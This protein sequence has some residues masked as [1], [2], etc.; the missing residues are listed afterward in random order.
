M[1]DCF[2]QH[3]DVYGAELEEEEAAA[4]EAAAAAKEEGQGAEAAAAAPK[5][6]PA[7]TTDAPA[8]LTKESTHKDATAADKTMVEAEA[9]KVEKS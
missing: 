8:D 9:A 5:D 4:A 3:P 1:Q 2:R 6:A 7:P